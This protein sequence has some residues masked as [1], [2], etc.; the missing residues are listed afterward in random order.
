MREDVITFETAKLAK[1]KGFTTPITSYANSYY[2][3]LGQ[4]KE[5]SYKTKLEDYETEAPTQALLQR[6]LRE[7]H[8]LHIDIVA[9]MIPDDSKQDN[10]WSTTFPILKCSGKFYANVVDLSIENREK[11][12]GSSNMATY[13]ECLEESLIKALKLIK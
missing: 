7:Q 5:V 12:L 4:Y 13:E 8:Q 3:E 9:Q 11:G 1:E 10:T 2:N 6:W